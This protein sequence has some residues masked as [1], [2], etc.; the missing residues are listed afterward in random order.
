MPVPPCAAPP[1]G[2][3]EHHFSRADN[4]PPPR[5]HP[6]GRAPGRGAFGPASPVGPVQG[7]K[8]PKRRPGRGVWGRSLARRGSA[9]NGPGGSSAGRACFR[10]RPSHRPSAGRGPGCAPV[11]LVR[12]QGRGLA[13]LRSRPHG[14]APHGARRAPRRGPQGGLA[15]SGRSL[16]WRPA[17]T[18]APGCVRQCRGRAHR[19]NTVS[20]VFG[21]SPRLRP[22]QAPCGARRRWG[23]T[24]RPAENGLLQPCTVAP[25]PGCRCIR[26][27]APAAP[28]P[29]AEGGLRWR[30]TGG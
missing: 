16:P 11:P 20:A 22:P 27:K 26:R 28:G 2:R 9:R 12:T 23:R 6:A 18:A 19:R 17:R 15:L 24:H 30:W 7:R 1:A 3:S 8:R 21:R 25:A 10:P 5:G 14:P 4:A 13:A 29:S